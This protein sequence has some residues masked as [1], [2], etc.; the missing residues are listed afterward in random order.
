[1]SAR[2]DGQSKMK[3]GPSIEFVAKPYERAFGADS[4]AMRSRPCSKCAERGLR[5]P[6]HRILLNGRG[7][8]DDCYRLEF[9]TLSVQP[10]CSRVFK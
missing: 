7:L 3:R 4:F 1:M 2:R 9:P 6:A 8:C 5:V 10:P